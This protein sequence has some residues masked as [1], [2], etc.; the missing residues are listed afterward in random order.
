MFG[1]I[2]YIAAAFLLLFQP[3]LMAQVKLPVYADSLFSTYYQQRLSLFQSLPQ[4]NNEIFFLGNSITDG[5]EWAQLFND[6]RMVNQGISGEITE[7][8]LHRLDA[9]TERKPAKVFLLIGTND[10]ARANNV[11]SV[12]KNILLIADYIRQ[13]S[14]YTKLFVQSILPVNEVYGKFSGHTKNTTAIQQLNEKLRRN[15]NEHHYQ[16]ID[17]YSAFADESGRLRKGLTN[18]GLHLLGDGYLLWKHIIYP[19]VY[20]LSE[21][22]AIIPQP[23][24]LNWKDGLFFL[25]HCKTI[26]VSGEELDN[27]AKQLQQIIKSLGRNV[28]VANDITNNAPFI[29]LKL[30]KVNSPYLSHE[31]YR[32]K[33]ANDKI[34]IEANTPHGIFNGIQTLKQ[35]L[36]DGNTADACEITDWPVF[37]WRGYMIDVGRNYMTM[38]LLKQQ[39]EVMAR[40]KLNVFHFHPTEDIAWRFAIKQYPQL[41]AS[42]AMLRNKGE[43]YS[44]K[45]IEELIQFCK[46]R[47]ITFIREIDMPGHSAAF[48]RA[49]G[50]DMQSDSGLKIVKNIL[51]EICTTYDV[52]YIHIGADEVKISNKNFIPEITSFI[53]SF[54]K[55]VIGWQPGGNFT[56]NTIRQLWMEDKAHL[57][58]QNKLQF[59]DSRHLYLNHIDPLEAVTAIYNREIGDIAQGDSLMLGA[60]LCIWN[61]RRVEN[62]NDIL[63]MNPVYPGILT[64]AERCWRGGGQ[65]GWISNISDGDVEG[66]KKFENRLSDHKE[67]YFNDLPFPYVKQSQMQWLLYGPYNND[68]E[69]GKKFAPELSK[70]QGQWKFYKKETGGTIVLRHWWYPLIK[71]AVDNPKENATFY[72]YTKIWS[73]EEGPHY[74]W[75]GFNDI[76]RSPATDSPPENGWDYKQSEIWLNG[77]SVLP[78]HWKHAGQKGDPEVPLVDEGY[79]YRQPTTI[80]LQKG[81]NDILLKCPVGSFKGKDWQNPVKWEFTFVEVE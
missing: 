55:K 65:K 33:I 27:E 57:S 24:Q 58:K 9:V 3:E 77:K 28:T 54:G 12:L 22:P 73:D 21:K 17:L 66:F 76:S 69:L 53:E 18:D 15:V 4:K 30:A 78:P 51:K 59:I 37:S 1:I 40:Y 62:G 32:L 10:L 11:D 64:F 49:M 63:R 5:G 44:Q 31:A 67:I 34:L 2:K 79:S 81:W 43:Y 25:N 6:A 70:N 7:G 68:G 61:D 23:Q 45:D 52:P 72:A 47:Y 39:I 8:V 36:R 56:Q 35:L 42:S 41:T 14:P 50:V 46:E 60:T 71:G 26:R 80:F 16:Y 19:Y 13:V 20:G 75:I 48:K 74:F 29:E 38:D